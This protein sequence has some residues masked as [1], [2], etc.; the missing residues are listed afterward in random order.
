[1]AF[2]DKVSFSKATFSSL[3]VFDGAMFSGDANFYEAAFEHNALFQRA[4]F[5]GGAGFTRA[6]FLAFADTL[7]C[8]FTACEF[9][10]NTS[11]SGAVFLSHT[12]DFRDAKLP[13]ATEWDDAKWPPPPEDIDAAR[14]QIYAFERLKAE[15]E[16]SK[17]HEDEQFFFA[18]ELSARRAL[19]WFKCRD[20]ER[21]IGERAKSAIG[22]L[23]NAA[24]TTFSGYGLSIVRPLVWLIALFFL[25]AG[26]FAATASLD[27]GPMNLRQAAEFS[28][29]NLFPF[30]PNKA[31]TDITGHLSIWTKYFG[32]LQ[33]FLG[34][35]LL[36]LLGLA[37]RNR[38]RMK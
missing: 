16:R 8:D 36:F 11:F 10:S 22:W 12:P 34:V 25:C 3:T 33:S 26:V 7:A 9:K 20:G 5:S 32:D 35:L 13:E 29:T 21:A 30:L 27:G 14:S 2:F 4:T 19:L 1:V 28:V 31:G 23:L 6:S 24:Y 17:R 15:M 37:L 38:F 18:K